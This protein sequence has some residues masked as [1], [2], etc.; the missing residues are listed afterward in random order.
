MRGLAIILLSLFL[1]GVAVP[2]ISPITT[3]SQQTTLPPEEHKI[4]VAV[5]L[6]HGESDKY[7]NY[8]MGNITFV[9]WKI[10]NGTVT[11]DELKDVDIFII[12]Q[13]TTG[14]TP[15]EMKA[16][17]D[18][19]ASGNKAIWVAGDSDYG[20]GPASQKAANDLLA[21]IG[22]KLRVE[23]GSVYDDIH[24]AGRFYRVLGY[25]KPD[26]Y[27]GLFTY[28]ISEGI[29]KPVLYHG[30][31]PV[32]WVDENGKAHDPVNDTFPGLIRIVWTG[33][34]AYAADNN[35]PPPMVYNPLFYGK[36]TGNHTFVLLAAEYHKDKNDLIIV[37]G[38]SP[39]GDYEPTWAWYYHG[40]A[41][42]GPKFVTNMIRWMFT[43]LNFY[44]E[45]NKY[46]KLTV[47]VDLAH[48]ESD[49]YLNYIMGNITFVNWKVINSTITAD[50]L[51]GVD[52]LIIGQPTTGFTP[53]E[54]KAISDWLASGD[55][56]MWVAGDSDYGGGPSSQKAANDLLAAIGAKL[57]VEYGSVYDDIHCAGRFYRVLGYVKPDAYPGLDTLVI[58]DS[59]TKPVLYHGPAP[60]VWVDENGKAHDPVNETFPGLIRIVW[61]GNTAYAADN[62][63]PAPMVYNP[64]FYGKGTGNH[65]FVLLAAEYHPSTKNIIVVSG[66]SPYGDYEP[67]WAWYYHG[68]ALSGPEFVTNMIRWF[69][70]NIYS[71]AV[72]PTTTTTTTTTTTS[73]TQTTA[74]TPT[75][76]T[77]T[78][79]SPTTTT[80]LPTSPTTTT[81]PPPN[82]TP[83]LIAAIIIAI[84]IIIAAL[85]LR[86]R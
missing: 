4:T 79:Q 18:W 62:N 67:T 5:D 82:Y 63:P 68:V 56:I 76:T 57:R 11:A 54:M 85:A 60:V 16:I 50:T 80:T 81:T 21:A 52:I 47:A 48:G 15:D 58:S 69:V 77:T 24:C 53:D 22:A 73:P 43:L 32:V 41:L 66:E 7:L 70:L 1:I 19:L 38:E 55:K 27:T 37:S 12:G 6:G 83:V 33:N 64:L 23:Y 44:E 84:I 74:T 14:F 72:P 17:S 9:N 26:I 49:K 8:I 61:T 35:P 75:T 29:T 46:G 31:A 65:T 42:D 34:T 28:I 45:V 59:V 13:P 71:H 30:P 36:G 3:Y 86:R 51:K 78:T 20:G 25:V 39:Y 2:L 40:V 10:I